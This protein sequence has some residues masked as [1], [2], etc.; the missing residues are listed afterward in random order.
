MVHLYYVLWQWRAYLFVKNIHARERFDLVHHITL[1][2]IR[3]PS[4]LGRL[5]PPFIFGPVGGGERAP[6]RL[7]QGYGW[8]GW[9]VDLIRDAWN[10]VIRID[11]LIQN[12]FKKA[13]SIYVKTW[14][15]RPVIPR[16]Y[17][18]KVR[19][20]LE[21]GSVPT[22]RPIQKVFDQTNGLRIGYVGRFVYWKGMHLGLPAFARLAAVY[23]RV[24]LTLVG[25][26][27]EEL[28]W[29]ALAEQLGISDRLSWIPW[30]THEEL[31]SIYVQQ[32]VL[33]F[34]S[35]HDSS[36]NVVLEAMSHGLP[37][38]CLDLGGPGV[39]VDEICGRV[40]ATSGATRG[41]VIEKLTD[42]LLELAKDSD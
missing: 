26:G 30:V 12:T 16:K 15:S 29:R 6:W 25:S 3:L 4:F 5:G 10:F 14:D 1:G 37:V 34:P 22:N 9:I 13:D 20:R 21:I 42:A 41:C 2:A 33:L 23:P 40:I 36:G 35:L 38:V 8:R 27:P 17:W 31:K 32:D 28:R 7:R 11:P 19:C 39:M 24:H 18:P